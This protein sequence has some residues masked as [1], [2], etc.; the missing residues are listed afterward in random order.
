MRGF[1]LALVLGAAVVLVSPALAQRG[2]GPGGGFGPGILLQNKSVQEELKIDADQAKKITE[3]FTK[4]REDL[5]DEYAKLGFRSEASDEE[6]AEARKKINEAEAKAVKEVL[7]D[8]QQKRFQQIRHQVQG[9]AIF[10]DE[11]VKK[12]LK[13]TAEQNEKIE[14]IRKDLQKEVQEMFQGFKPGEKPDPSQ[15]QENMK[16]MQGLQKEAMT[17]AT[18]VLNADQKKTLEELTGKPFNYVP[19][20]GRG[21]RG[22]KP[23]KPR[24]DF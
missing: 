18:K 4:L 23:D 1:K 21:G 8:D 14:D 9:L 2:R 12:Q 24:T 22:G 3:T 6:K 11:E 13:L 19:E 15:F 17:N 20:F 5:R 10:Q 16:K 7:K